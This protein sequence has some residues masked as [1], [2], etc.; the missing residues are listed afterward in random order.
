MGRMRYTVDLISRYRR[1]FGTVDGA[2]LGEL[3]GMADRMIF[4]G[5]MAYN[6][7][8]WKAAQAGQRRGK[9]DVE[10]YN[11]SGGH[12][13]EMTMTHEDEKLSFAF[14]ALT[15]E[16]EGVFGPPPLMRFQR[17][18]N[19]SVTEVDGGDEAEVVENFGVNSWEIDIDGLLV[20]MDEHA[21]PGEK[22]K[23]L[24]K[25]FE[26]NDVIEVA[27]PLL[28]DMGIRSIYLK[29]QGIEPVEGFPDTVKYSLKAK[30]IKPALFS[31][32]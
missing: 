27:C 25:F 17:T 10:R 21:Y 26:I 9:Y 20:D 5:G 3:E 12:W 14:G 6:E 19:I 29:D 18:K 28:L 30:S 22:V 32:I 15:G 2:L 31:L 1:A 11:T 23:K 13:A 7:A 16:T 8:R 24:V 4:M